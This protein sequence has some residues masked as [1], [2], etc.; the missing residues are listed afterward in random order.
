MHGLDCN[1]SALVLE[2]IKQTKVDM[3][4]YLGNYP[5]A[6]D[7]GAAYVRQRDII[8]EALQT[9]GVDHVAGVTVGNEFVLE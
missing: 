8:K 4:V 9:Y 5:I 2:A 7:A 6:T 3:K 1:Q